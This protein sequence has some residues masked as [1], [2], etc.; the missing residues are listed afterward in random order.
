[1]VRSGVLVVETVDVGHEKQVIRLNHCRCY[2]REGVVVSEFD[3]LTRSVSGLGELCELLTETA[4]VSFSLTM[5]I[6]PILSSSTNV[7]WALRYCVRC[8]HQ[9]ESRMFLQILRS[10]TSAISFLV[11][12]IWATGCRR[13]P[14]KLSHR[15]ISRHCPTAAN[16]YVY[17][18]ISFL[19]SCVLVLLTTV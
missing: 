2:G 15:L 12:K 8:P 16:A 4:R 10:L 11:S 5:G 19:V 9:H 3:F 7:F 18:G 14:N 17:Q 13:C 6:T 1:M